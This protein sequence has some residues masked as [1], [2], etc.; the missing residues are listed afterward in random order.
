MANFDEFFPFDPG[1]GATANAARWR[2]MAQLWAADGVLAN[3]LN[4]LNA[5]LAGST[6]TVQSGAVFIH[7][8][9]AELQNNQTF[10]MGTNG[11]LVA[12]VNFANEVVALVYRDTITDY[13]AGG[14]EQDTNVWEIPIWGISGGNT[15][16]DLRNLVNPAN[17][18]RWVAN[19]QGA[20]TIPTGQTNQFSFGAAR[21]PYAAQGFLHGTLL[22]TFSDLSQA[23]TVTCSLTYQYGQ[24]DQ[25]QTPTISPAVTAGGVVNQQ[26]SIPVSLFGVV[27]VTQG[28]KTFGWRVQAG[29]GPGVSVA[30]LNLSLSTGGR[31]PVV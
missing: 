14:F 26:L 28:K 21:I 6:L 20:T 4:Q 18:L 2:K 30:Q 9:Y 27:P 17:G 22:L 15:L 3:Y 24:G 31:P 19:Q 23:Q 10:T 16:L 12:Q 7:G 13:G 5:T 8:Y 29:P 25:Q 1:Y 11:T